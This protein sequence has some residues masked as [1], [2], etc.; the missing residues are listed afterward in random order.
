MREV[1]RYTAEPVS[2][3]ESTYMLVK[4]L[5]ITYAK[6]ELERVATNTTHMNAE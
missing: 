3:R 6:A 2:T 4:L 1:A 5:Y